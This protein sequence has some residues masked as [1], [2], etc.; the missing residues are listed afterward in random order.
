[1]MAEEVSVMTMMADVMS[2]MANVM[3]VIMTVMVVGHVVVMGCLMV[4]DGVESAIILET[5]GLL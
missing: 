4:N 2:M 1:M 5:V 3:T